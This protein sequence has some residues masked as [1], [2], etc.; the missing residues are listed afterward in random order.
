MIRSSTRKRLEDR[1]S[2]KA[3]QRIRRKITNKEQAMFFVRNRGNIEKLEAKFD[4]DM[5]KIIN[6]YLESLK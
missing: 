5:D 4:R 6:E 2:I 3:T 1:I